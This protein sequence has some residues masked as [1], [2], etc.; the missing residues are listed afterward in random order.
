MTEH[1]PT[2]VRTIYLCSKEVRIKS[3]VHLTLKG[4]SYTQIFYNADGVVKD[5]AGSLSEY[6]SILVDQ[7]N[8]T[9]MQREG[10]LNGKSGSV[11]KK[12]NFKEDKAKRN[13][14]RN[15]I[16]R[17]KKD[18]ANLENSMEKLKAKA[19]QVQKEIDASS[20]EGWTVLA[21]LTAKL[22]NLNEE[23]EEKEIL[24]MEVAEILESAEVEM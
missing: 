10:E 17:A 18:I 22:D 5:F 15:A 6:A 2:S 19:A 4:H 7:E 20:D 9:I 23:I 21:D 14:Q 11:E 12:G 24:W 8:D 1:L 3:A 16:R 13:E